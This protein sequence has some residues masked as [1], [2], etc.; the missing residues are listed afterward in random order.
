MTAKLLKSIEFFARTQKIF[1][2][3]AKSPSGIS[4][5]SGT[6]GISRKS[7]TPGISG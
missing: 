1:I 5:K 3:F 7:G 6:P 4:G 2:N